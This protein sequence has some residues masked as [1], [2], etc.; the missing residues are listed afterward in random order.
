MR[1]ME[2]PRAGFAVMELLIAMALLGVIASFIAG[3]LA[4]GNRVWERASSVSDNG[5]RLSELGF[6]RDSLSQSLMFPRTAGARSAF[7]GQTDAI[8]IVTL[9][10]APGFAADQ[11]WRI[12][13]SRLPGQDHLT[14]GFSPDFSGPAQPQE[15]EILQHLT[16]FS[17]RYFGRQLDQDQVRWQIDWEDQPHLPDLIEV[18]LTFQ[19]EG[20]T[21]NRTLTIR[22]RAH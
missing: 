11:P 3:S 16:G 22:P 9:R 19:D 14:V 10:A 2:D 12:S 15:R 6:L 1:R 7:Q 8:S 5:R 13:F 17:V 4:F 20:A 21:T 18:S